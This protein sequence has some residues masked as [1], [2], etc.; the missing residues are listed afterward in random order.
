MLIIRS[1]MA[2]KIFVMSQIM[3]LSVTLNILFSMSTK[4]MYAF[5]SEHEN[6]VLVSPYMVRFS[7]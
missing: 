7:H 4:L 5:S 1:G 6:S 2:S 3:R